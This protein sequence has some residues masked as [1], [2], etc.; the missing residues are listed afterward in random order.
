MGRS[1]TRLSPAEVNKLPVPDSFDNQALNRHFAVF[2]KDGKLF[3]SEFETGSAG[4]DVFRNTQEVKWIV[5]A[6]ANGYGGL[7]Q[8]GEYLFEA[9]LSYY[10]RT[11]HWESSPG[12]EQE[13]NGFHRPALAGC[14]SCHAGRPA[15]MEQDT[16]RYAPDPFLQTAIGCENCHGPGEAHVRAMKEDKNRSQG[17]LIV[18]P[19]KLSAD[20]E[21][22]ICMSCHEA[23]DSRVPRPGKTFQDFRPG[24]P[25]DESVSILMVPL[26]QGDADTHDHVQHY[27]EMSMSKCFRGSARQLRCA[28]CHDPHVEPTQ[29][30][31]PEYFNQKCM[32]CHENSACKASLDVR[33]KTTP[34]DN[35]IG[36]H[37]PQRQAPETAHTSL[38]NH[39]ILARVGEPWPDAAFQQTTPELPDLIHLNRARS[40]ADDL[41]AVS[42][43]EAYREIAERKP[44][45]GAAYQKALSELEQNDPNHAAVQ[46]GLGK[47]ELA[48][49]ALDDAVEHLR[50]SIALNPEG[51]LSQSLLSEA[52]ARQG[53]MEEA[54]G[55]SET[56]V[57][58][59]PYNPLFQKSLI[60]HLIEAKEYDKATAAM[61]HYL[62][63]FPED[64]FMRKMLA[65][66]KE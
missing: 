2:A 14:I 8:H 46:E 36:C 30:E 28:T 50:K 37:M 4:E 29:E 6:G 26:K 18:N 39:R 25:L 63:L 21:N 65:M 53:H 43:L 7:M 41:P 61:E 5:G 34:S 56:A 45:Y 19:G 55:A 51:G 40:R 44:E 27:F 47:R 9:P 38:T 11:K 3:Q 59:E 17:T 49:G 22:D 58:L 1:I 32:N 57:N 31:A 54:V 42:L 12:Y 64:D 66:A 20:L 16:G 33:Q 24:K 48:A 62:E 52:L 60:N 13:D 10:T 35:C 23:G 15:P